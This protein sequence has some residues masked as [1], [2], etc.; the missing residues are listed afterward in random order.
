MH[1]QCPSLGFGSLP[2]AARWDAHGKKGQIWPPAKY[3]ELLG[4]MGLNSTPWH[5]HT[6]LGNP[7]L[8]KKAP[9]NAASLHRA[10]LSQPLRGAV[11]SPGPCRDDSPPELGLSQT[12]THPGSSPVPSM[13]PQLAQ[14]DAQ[15]EHSSGQVTGRTHVESQCPREGSGPPKISPADRQGECTHKSKGLPKAHNVHYSHIWPNN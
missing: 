5:T 2:S 14:E 10:E 15:P 6:Q 7:S 4:W 1:S 8:P 9:A 13:H 11:S 3:R 12:Q